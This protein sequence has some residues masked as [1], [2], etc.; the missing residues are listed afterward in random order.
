MVELVEITATITPKIKCAC[1][2]DIGFCLYYIVRDIY[3]NLGDLYG[4]A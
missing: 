3:Y 2:L 1:F 4:N